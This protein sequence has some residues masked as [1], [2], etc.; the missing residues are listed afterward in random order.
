ME[1]CLGELH[2]VFKCCTIQGGVSKICWMDSKIS[3]QRKNVE[4]SKGK[5]EG[6]TRGIA[7]SKMASTLKP[8]AQAPH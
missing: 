6:G 1:I 5:I 4:K 3:Y 8:E 7:K 2:V